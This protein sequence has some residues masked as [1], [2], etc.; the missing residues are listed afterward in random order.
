[1]AAVGFVTRRP[2]TA[3]GGGSH[4]RVA[5]VYQVVASRNERR[6]LRE[7]E[8]YEG[9][10]FVSAPKPPERVLP[11]QHALLVRWQ[12][13]EEGRLD[14]ARSHAIDP[15]TLRPVLGGRVLREPH[16]AMLGGGVRTVAD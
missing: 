5:A 2:Q 13:R 11:D 14:V 1:M 3:I 7:E 10:D 6:L 15:E 8:A 12:G 4:R 16:D 9:G